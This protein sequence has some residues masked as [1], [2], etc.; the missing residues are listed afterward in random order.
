VVTRLVQIKGQFL[1]WP[2]SLQVNFGGSKAVCTPRRRGTN[3]VKVNQ[4]AEAAGRCGFSFVL[5][6]GLFSLPQQINRITRG[7]AVGIATGQKAQLASL[8]L[9]INGPC[10]V[11]RRTAVLVIFQPR[12]VETG[13]KAGC[14]W[15][16]FRS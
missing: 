11:S 14:F 12:D 7:R 9:R 8:A 4:N 6:R 1:V 15:W 2:E 5:V 16:C 3:F 10:Q 13:L